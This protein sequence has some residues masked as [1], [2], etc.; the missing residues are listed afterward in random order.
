MNAGAARRCG[1]C[2]RVRPISKRAGPDGPDICSGCYRP[3]IAL[4]TVGGQQRPCTGVGA[5]RAVC[6]RCAPRRLS[7]C[8]HCS[9]DRPAVTHW[10][11]G[12]VCDSCYSAA[13]RRTGICAGCG[14][15][16]RLLCPPGPGAST[17]ADCAGLVFPGHVC[18]GCGREDKLFESGYCDRCS[19]ARRT[20]ELLAGADHQVPAALAGV[21]DALI[22]T[23]RPRTAL[24]WL[25]R[26]KGAPLLSAV[27]S[28]QIPPDWTRNPAGVPSTSFAP[29]SS[30]TARCPS[31]TRAWSGSNA[32]SGSCWPTSRTVR[33]A[34]S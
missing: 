33:T 21:R 5:G 32:I 1:A 3:P 12:L 9:R 18:A 27:A 17:C 7:R 6:L 28:G 10:P 11:E 8:A 19:L 22:A 14:Q 20:D 15:W 26:G 16:R 2:G 24:N 4:C 13:L 34:A 29:S 30:L 25:R 23:P 31:G